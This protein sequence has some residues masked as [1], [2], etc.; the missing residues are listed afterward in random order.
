MRIA[1]IDE[2]VKAMT[3]LSRGEDFTR[4]SIHSPDFDWSRWRSIDTGKPVMAGH[5]L[6]G[7]A[8]VSH[9]LLIFT[10]MIVLNELILDVID[11]GCGR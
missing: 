1:E 9:C 2:V 7:S 5:S 4:T 8:A 6:G 11:R 3:R 10:P